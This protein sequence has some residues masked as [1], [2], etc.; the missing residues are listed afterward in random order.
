MDCIVYSW[1]H[2]TIT[3]ELIEIASTLTLM[4]HSLWLEVE[5]QFVS[6]REMCPLILDIEFR[7][8][9]HGDLSIFDYCY[10]LKGMVDA[11]CDL[12]EVVLDHSLVLI[13]L[14]DLN[15]RFS[16]MA[17]LLKRSHPFSTFAQV[18]NDV[19]LKEIELLS[20]TGSYSMTLVA[21]TVAVGR[22]LLPTAL[23]SPSPLTASS[24]PTPA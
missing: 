3:P 12:G 7:N 18:C 1:L 9:V 13:M 2:D 23:V 24:A 21:T 16:H 10:H 17:A 20:K 6:N 14:C 22:T 5:E 19:Q 4:A 8:F 15:D 11:L